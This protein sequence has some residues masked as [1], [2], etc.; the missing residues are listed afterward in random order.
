M[1][2]Q[3]HTPAHVEIKPR[4]REHAIADC[5]GREWFG[6]HSFKTAWFNAMS[7]TFPLGEK[8]FIDSVRHYNDQITDPKL[9]AEIKGFCGQENVHRREHERYNKTLCEKRGYDLEYL[10]GRIAKKIALSAKMYSPIQLLSITAALEHITAIMA[11]WSLNKESTMSMEV[12]PAIR[13]LWDWHAVEEMEHKAVA[14]D[15]YRAVGGTEKMR[16]SSLRRASF[17]LTIDILGGM[18][19]MLK[20]DK[21]LWNLKL[22]WQ[23]MGFLFGKRGVMRAIYPAWKEYFKDDFH[24]WQRD[25]QEILDTWKQE[26]VSPA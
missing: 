3:S 16:K 9:I 25:T 17:F 15:V 4:N 11:E 19:H 2:Q 10:E 26:Q 18:F 12:E 14:F 24:P 13:E 21:K 6:G 20:R 5:L 22:W 1:S 23:G 8:F 7:I